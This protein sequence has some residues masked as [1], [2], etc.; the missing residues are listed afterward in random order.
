M[1]DMNIDNDWIRSR[2]YVPVGSGVIAAASTYSIIGASGAKPYGVHPSVAFGAAVAI[3]SNI[4]DMTKD[5]VLD[6]L[7]QS[8]AASD[9]Q[10]AIIGPSLTGLAAVGVSTVLLSKPTMMGA[11]YMFGI[12]AGSEIASQYLANNILAPAVEM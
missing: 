5:Y 4:S 9:F 11:V 12:G 2:L 3:G 8:Q 10:S 1:T 7:N 6:N